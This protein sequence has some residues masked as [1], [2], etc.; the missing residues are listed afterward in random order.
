[1]GAA[2]HMS[3]CCRAGQAGLRH[4][5][6][7]CRAGQAGFGPCMSTIYSVHVSIVGQ[8]V[9]WLLRLVGCKWVLSGGSVCLVACAILGTH[10]ACLVLTC[11]LLQVLCQVCMRFPRCALVG[12]NVLHRQCALRGAHVLLTFQEPQLVH[13]GKRAGAGTGLLARAWPRRAGSF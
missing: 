10:V 6:L 2:R 13:N 4:M 8:C 7:C 12:A 11:A 3:L 5:S 9:A 1:M